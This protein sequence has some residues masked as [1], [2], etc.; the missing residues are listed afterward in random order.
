MHSK[1]RVSPV[2][3]LTRGLTSTIDSVWRFENWIFELVIIAG[4]Q[5]LRSPSC[6]PFFK[7]KQHGRNELE[8]ALSP[9]SA[10]YNHKRCATGLK[11]DSMRWVV[12]KL[13]CV[14]VSRNTWHLAIIRSWN[15]CCVPRGTPRHSLTR[16]SLRISRFGELRC[17]LHHPFDVL[18]SR[19]V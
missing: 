6:P 11:R 12:D 15:V 13:R 9:I 4:C 19:R 5:A 3:K 2:V 16:G 8:A 14:Q 18:L 17:A 1:G 10:M 7:R